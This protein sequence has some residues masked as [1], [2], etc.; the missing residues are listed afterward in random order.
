MRRFFFAAALAAASLLAPDALANGRF[1]QSNHVFFSQKNPDLVWLRVTFGA[2]VSHDRGKTWDWVCERSIGTSGVEDPMYSLGP[3]GRILGTTFEGVAVS[4]DDACTF[5]FAQPPLSMQAFIDLS[6]RPDG[7][8]VVFFTS[9]Y[10]HEDDAGNL[11]FASK[12]YETTDEAQTVTQLTGVIPP[13]ILGETIDTAATDADRLYVSGT[14]GAGGTTQQGALLT[15][16]DHGKTFV[17]SAIDY[18]NGERS[19]FIAGVDPKNADRVYLRTLNATDQP[20]R[21]IV[22]EDGGKTFK[23]IF[24]GKGTLPGFS[25]SADGSKIYVGGGL[26]GVLVGNASDYTFAQ[27]SM[28]PVECLAAAAD[29]LWACSSEKGGFVAGLSTDDGA[30]FTAKLHFCDIRGP[31]SCGASTST[32][33][34]CPNLWPAQRSTLGCDNVS[35]GQ[36]GGTSSSSSSS[37]S[38]SNEGG[39]M[40]GGSACMLTFSPR[41]SLAAAFVTMLA[42][43]ALRARRRRR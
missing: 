1:P 25:L 16:K 42:A 4:S 8:S 6:T 34:Q 11:V 31:L 37:S 30:T 28:V 3:S 14:K 39:T 12:I 5:A 18:M 9:T 21:L 19:I 40:G 24:T 7:K 17:E 35:P 22:T 27:K 29:G 26:D 15:S 23:T 38:G 43:I 20:A 36:D 2:L 41:T 13:D 10:D 32:G 33:S